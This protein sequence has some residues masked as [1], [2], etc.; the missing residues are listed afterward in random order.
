[1]LTGL[2]EF[3]FNSWLG[4]RALKA[5][6][7]AMAALLI[8][9]PFIRTLK[10]VL[11]DVEGRAASRDLSR[12]ALLALQP[13]RF[14][15]ELELLQA[16]SRYR[17][18]ALPFD[19]QMR[20]L[21]LFYPADMDRER[22]FRTDSPADI[23]RRQEK[24]RRFLRV[25]AKRLF[26]ELNI[27]ATVSAGVH[28]WRDLDWGVAGMSSGRP[29]LVLHRENFYPRPGNQE[30]FD[31]RMGA[32]KPF[33][34]TAIA[35]HN[36]VTR[37]ALVAR[38]YCRE[39]QAEALGVMR[40]DAFVR[41]I[42]ERPAMPPRE[43]P[44]VV[45]FS[46]TE[47]VGMSHRMEIWSPDAK[48]G[49]AGLFDATHAA[50]VRLAVGRPDIDVVVKFKTD[51]Y[52]ERRFALALER[53]GLPADLPANLTLTQEANAQTLIEEASVVVAF[54]STTTLE[55]GLAGKPVVLPHFAEVHDPSFEPYAHFADEPGLFDLADSADD[56][57]ARI[58]HRLENPEIDAACMAARRAAFER[59]ISPARPCAI[60]NYADFIDRR[61]DAARQA[62]PRGD[63]ASV[64]RKAAY[65]G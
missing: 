60:A 42:A 40:M 46:F 15:G 63:P 61:V 2:A 26:D 41:A 34:G 39:D 55:A 52:I 58:V 10:G 62:A 5:T 45:L 44:L 1:M 32:W 54:N 19:W 27:V 51:S 29:F 56:L 59:L 65:S 8:T 16:H 43:R 53:E 20:F 31:V 9:G 25:L 38:G 28:Y 57:I 64:L 18:L 49:W 4:R 11:R 21:M 23:G 17:V 3:C 7:R 48:G 30:W 12:P 47:G 22:L 14:R 6:A 24:L 33:E 36:G 37:D 50:I 35:T 13:N